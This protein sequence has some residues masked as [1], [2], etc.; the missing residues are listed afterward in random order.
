V[1]SIFIA[2][3][4]MY[5]YIYI[6]IYFFF[7]FYRFKL[8]YFKRTNKNNKTNKYSFFFFVDNNKTNALIFSKVFSKLEGYIYNFK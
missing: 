4:C 8:N 7:K 3:C 6:Y 2:M 5:V 1:S